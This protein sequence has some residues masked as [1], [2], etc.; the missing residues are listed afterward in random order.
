MLT[1]CSRRSMCS[2]AIC[3]RAYNGTVP[4]CCVRAGSHRA[5]RFRSR[6]FPPPIGKPQD[7]G[8]TTS[9]AGG[10]VDGPPRASWYGPCLWQ[11]IPSGQVRTQSRHDDGL[12]GSGCVD[13]MSGGPQGSRRPSFPTWVDP[14]I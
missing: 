4:A 11:P 8:L 13:R 12:N 9:G 7:G 1:G 6:T 2:V 14:L 3:C 10:R 5:A